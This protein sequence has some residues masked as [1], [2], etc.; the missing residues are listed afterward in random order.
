MGDFLFFQ[1][2]MNPAANTRVIIPPAKGEA[3]VSASMG[4]SNFNIPVFSPGNLVE[5]LVL[6][7]EIRVG[8]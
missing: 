8:A 7:Q 5:I 6:I 4:F 3:A 2:A 1:W